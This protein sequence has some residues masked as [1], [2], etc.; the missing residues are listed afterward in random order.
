MNQ[1]NEKSKTKPAPVAAMPP[2]AG[3]A[4]ARRDPW[5]WVERCVWTEAML[6]RLTSREPADRV[7][8][9]LWDKTYAP[10]NLQRA[11]H[12][13]QSK[14]G[15]AGVDRWTVERMEKQLEPELAGLQVQLR[16]GKYRPQPVLRRYID[17]PGSKEKRPLIPVTAQ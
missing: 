16:S 7:W 10:A 3:E 12:K 13:V 15:S 9:R 8:F 17:K 2:Q 5:W 1:D 4:A 14:G 11:F 6:T